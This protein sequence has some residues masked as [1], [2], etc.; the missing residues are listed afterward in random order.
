MS[1]E[2]D[3]R[4]KIKAS[5][6][7]MEEFELFALVFGGDVHH[8]EGLK[9]IDAKFEVITELNL[10]ELQNRE[11][12]AINLKL[13][14]E[15]GWTPKQTQDIGVSTDK[16]GKYINDIEYLRSMLRS[17]TASLKKKRKSRKKSK[18]KSRKKSRKKSRRKSRKKSK[19]KR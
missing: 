11:R 12:A 13:S 19:R 15:A 6:A 8:A 9:N 14:R 1:S 4:R 16:Y 7:S 3:I 17:V 10:K 2:E 5:R 18:N